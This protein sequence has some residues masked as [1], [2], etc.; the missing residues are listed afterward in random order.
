MD[1]APAL[2]S[3]LLLIACVVGAKLLSATRALYQV[4]IHWR[5]PILSKH[6]PLPE[7]AE[8]STHAPFCTVLVVT[9]GKNPHFFSK[10]TDIMLHPWLSR[11]YKLLHEK[12]EKKKR[13]VTLVANFISISKDNSKLNMILICDMPLK[14]C[15]ML[16][17]LTP[18]TWHV[19]CPHLHCPACNINGQSHSELRESKSKPSQISIFTH[20]TDGNYQG[21]TVQNSKRFSSEINKANFHGSFFMYFHS[22]EGLQIRISSEISCLLS[23]HTDPWQNEVKTSLCDSLQ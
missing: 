20:I 10:A 13:A 2:K 22:L 3:L 4:L 8:N 15:Y 9:A 6:F 1:L 14:L 21:N 7:K 5:L 19:L 18:C 23:C 16:R 12:T 17:M 11:V